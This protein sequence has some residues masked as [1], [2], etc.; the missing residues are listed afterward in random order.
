MSQLGVLTMSRGPQLREEVLQVFVEVQGEFPR[1]ALEGLVA[2]FFEE[3]GGSQRQASVTGVQ[4]LSVTGRGCWT[5]TVS[6]RE[7]NEQ[8]RKIRHMIQ[9]NGYT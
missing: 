8:H 3:S 6:A 2:E 9:S 7:S 1:E 4:A 5:Q